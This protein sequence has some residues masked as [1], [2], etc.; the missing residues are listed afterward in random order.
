MGKLERRDFLKAASAS[1]A[2][3]ALLRDTGLGATPASEVNTPTPLPEIPTTESMRSVVMTH[4]FGDHFNPPGLTNQWGCA[5]AAMDVTGVRSIAFPPFAQGE[6]NVAPLG[7]GGELLTGILYVDGE[8]FAATKTP[9]EF[10]WRPDRIERRSTYKG[11]ELS[12]VTVVPFRSMTTAVK[13]TV[14]NINKTRRKTEIKLA[15]NGGATKSVQP[16]NAAYSPGEYDNERTIESTRQAILCRSKRTEAFVLQGSSPKASQLLP[17]WLIYEFD[18]APGE[19]RSITFANTMGAT[20][21][22]ARS[23]FDAVIDRFD[24]VAKQTKDEWDAQLRAAFTPGNEVFSGH[25]PTLVTAD[26]DVKRLYH[27]AVMSALFFRRTTPHSVYGTTYVTLAPRYW[28][29]TTFLWDISLSAMLLAMLDPAVLRRMIETWMKLDVYKHFGTEYLTGAG[30]GP[31]YSVN[32]Y[33]MSRMAKE[34]LRWTGD[35]EWLEREVGGVKVFDRLIQYAEHWRSLDKNGHGLA[36]YGGVTNLLEAV[37]SY[38]HEVAGL[39]AANVY[40]LQFAADLLDHNGDK[41]KAADLRKEAAEL[42]G[43]VNALYV[44]GKGIWK[45]R[46][47]DGSYNEVHHC[48][49]FGVTLMT[50][51]DTMPATQKREMV[52]FFQRELQTPTWMRALSTR[53]LDV[54]FSIRPDHQWTGAYCAWPA[55]ALSGLFAAGEFKVA[56]SWIKGLAK[57]AQQGPIA[58]AH[59]VEDFVAPESNGGAI[60]APSDQPFIN[61]WACVSGCNYLEPIVD[62]IFGVKAGLFG[63]ISAKPNFSEFDQNAELRNLNYQGRKFTVNRRGLTAA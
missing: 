25:L 20:A 37:S 63:E 58:Q 9:V 22:E 35:K 46:L 53:D 11:L 18:L 42:T 47:P 23:G 17:S 12:S 55:L 54:T 4:K 8:Y 31:W 30:V 41:D 1:L 34:Y 26:D 62:S 43:R 15:V 29:T 24:E 10:V 50:I 32:D 7:A 5:Q 21:D 39:N 14:K 3:P 59:F 48:Y 45:C 52:E 40:N 33:A 57:S 44:D 19:S 36:D 51:G 28:E 38:V 56:R 2:L 27:S 13:L 60:K 61:D 6:M 16:W 49:D